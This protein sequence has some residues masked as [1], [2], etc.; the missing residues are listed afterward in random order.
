MPVGHSSNN[1]I[2]PSNTRTVD[3]AKKAIQEISSIHQR[4]Y[5]NAFEVNGYDCIVY[6]KLKQG[7]VCSCQGKRKTFTS[8]LKEDG[9]LPESTMNE[10]LTGGLEFKINLT[11][12][13]RQKPIASQREERG[14]PPDVNPDSFTESKRIS[15]VSNDNI[16]I[17]STTMSDG[18][19][20]TVESELIDDLNDFDDNTTFQDSACAV[21]FGTG[22][23]GGFSIQNGF[24]KC[25]TTSHAKTVDGVIEYNRLPFAFYA[26][27]V[28]FGVILPRG[29]VSLDSFRVMNNKT[30]VL[31]PVIKIDGIAY[32]SLLFKA[33]SDGRSHEISIEFDELT[34]FTH[35]EIQTNFSQH[36]TKIEFP[37]LELQKLESSDPTADISLVASSQ[38]PFLSTGDLIAES[39]F[40]K[41][42]SVYSVNSLVDNLKN[43]YGW[44]CTTRVVQRSE[45]LNLLPRRPVLSDYKTA[46]FSKDNQSGIRRT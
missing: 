14:L 43:T 46:N 15:G 12:T 36:A 23:I 30:P 38:I 26:K 1:R 27:K 21:C 16:D 37:K 45:I 34:Y 44:E 39:V 9:K 32:S 6:N 17:V 18:L 7:E 5:H 22:W 4:R 41:L 29:F 13:S 33:L 35:L 28:V 31:S 25:L 42:L 40:S 24:R 3:T 19:A 11:P 20:D 8:L 10:L 2:I